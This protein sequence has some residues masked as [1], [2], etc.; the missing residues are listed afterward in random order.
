MQKSEEEYKNTWRQVY[1]NIPEPPLPTTLPL[2]SYTGT[3]FH[4]AYNNITLEL[5]DDA[6][7]SNR[8]DATLKLEFRLEHISGDYFMAYA[9]STEAPGSVFKAA[10]PAEFKVSSDGIS[11]TLGL[12]AEP[13]MGPQGRIW[14]ERV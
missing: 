4:P 14:F 11:K 5:K 10:A 6:L 7:Y 3:Y 1:P 12:A 9:D 8:Q 13:E 2:R